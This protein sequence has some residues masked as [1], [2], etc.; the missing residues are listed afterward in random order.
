M[1]CWVAGILLLTVG[2]ALHPPSVSPSEFAARIVQGRIG[3]ADYEFGAHQ[4]WEQSAPDRM[5]WRDAVSVTLHQANLNRGCDA[6]TLRAVAALPWID[7]AAEAPD[8]WSYATEAASLRRAQAELQALIAARAAGQWDSAIGNGAAGVFVR[9][10]QGRDDSRSI[11]LLRRAIRDQTLR[12]ADRP[13]Y[14]QELAARQWPTL[15]ATLTVQVDCD[16]TVRLRRQLDDIS[17]FDVPTYG[18]V[19]DQAAWLIVQ[20]ADRSLEFQT[21]ALARLESLPDGRTDPINVAYLWDRVALADGRMQRYGTQMECENGSYRPA[22]GIE[23]AVNL[24]ARRRGV[25]LN[26]FDD[27]RRMLERQQPCAP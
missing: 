9:A 20:H 6:P 10:M 13:R 27:Y 15:V 8:R 11:E 25:G 3:P 19:I 23:D 22:I 26:S 2:C 7:L 12:S 17:W 14:L 5:S 16:N 1:R 18:R 21:M 24:D 4:F